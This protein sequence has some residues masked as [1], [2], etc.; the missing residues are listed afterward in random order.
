MVRQVLVPYNMRVGFSA[1]V[2][3]DTLI[4]F[5]V[6]T[7]PERKLFSKFLTIINREIGKFVLLSFI[8]IL[9]PEQ[10]N[11]LNSRFAGPDRVMRRLVVKR[12]L[13]S[14]KR[15]AW[16]TAETR[17]VVTKLMI[18]FDNDPRINF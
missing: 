13:Q 15:C 14:S 16:K 10:N 6:L 4:Q 1:H 17:D 3:P 5:W 2:F 12:Y 11:L 9:F 7:L 8:C 18:F